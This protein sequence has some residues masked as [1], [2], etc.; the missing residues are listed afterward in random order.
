[1][2]V[3]SSNQQGYGCYIKLCRRCTQSFDAVLFLYEN[4]FTFAAYNGDSKNGLT[5]PNGDIKS[6]FLVSL[7]FFG[8]Q[9]LV[10]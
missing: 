5:F 1:M 6:D 4:K 10:V 2:Y 9:C 8:V 3:I 7:V